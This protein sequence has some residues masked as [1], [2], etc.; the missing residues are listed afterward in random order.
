LACP[1]LLGRPVENDNTA[2][3][4]EPKRKRRWF[5]FSLRTLLVV[6]TAVAIVC[7]LLSRIPNEISWKQ[8]QSI[9]VGM[10]EDEV[11]E[12]LGR[13]NAVS[14][15]DYGGVDWKYGGFDEDCVEFRNG[16]VVSADKF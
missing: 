9:K 8:I 15:N 4:A 3:D 11:R 13:P 10:T 5:Q 2:M 12:I 16:R 1:G 7:A 14:P 6:V